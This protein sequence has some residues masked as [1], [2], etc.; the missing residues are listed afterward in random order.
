M[1]YL[2][3]SITGAALIVSVIALIVAIHR[4][5]VDQ[6]FDGARLATDSLTAALEGTRTNGG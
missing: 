5:R 4:P 2:T 6:R 1:T 3:P